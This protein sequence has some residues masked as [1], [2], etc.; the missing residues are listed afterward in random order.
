MKFE[1]KWFSVT[2]SNFSK[3]NSLKILSKYLNI[4]TEETINVFL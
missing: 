4:S 2:N 1:E 3:G